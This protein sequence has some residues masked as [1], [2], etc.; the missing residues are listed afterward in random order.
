MLARLVMCIVS[1]VL[2]AMPAL[3]CSLSPGTL[4]QSNFE[5]VES[6]EAIV[7]AR[8]VEEESDGAFTDVAFTVERVLK[9]TPTDRVTRRDARLGDP[10]PSDPYELL[11][12]NPEAY[13]GPC[14][15]RTFKRG[16]RYVLM[17]RDDPAYGFIV[18]GNAFS[19][20]SEDD[21][22]PGSYWGRA[23]ETYLKIQ[24]NPDR[25]AQL[26]VMQELARSGLQPGA[27]R[28]D[29]QLGIDAL[30]HVLGIHPDK[31]TA[32]LLQRYDDPTAIRRA[33][34]NSTPLDLTDDMDELDLFVFAMV[35]DWPEVTPEP[36]HERDEILSALAQGNHP[37]AAPLLNAILQDPNARP[38]RLGS[39]LGYLI[40][41]GAFERF[42]QIYGERIL[43]LEAIG[44]RRE[45]EDFWRNV[46][47]AIGYG[48][49]LNV[50]D[51]FAVWWEQQR[52]SVCILRSAPWE[53]RSSIA[54]DSTLLDDARAHATQVLLHARDP[55]VIDWAASEI[56][57]LQSEQVEMY[58]HDWELP[59]KVLLAGFHPGDKTRI[60]EFA[61]GTWRQ[62]ET[63]ARLIGEVPTLHTEDLLR[64]M[65][66]IE[67]HEYVRNSLLDSAVRIA[68]H[69]MEASS[70]ANAEFVAA[71][72]RSDGPLPLDEGEEWMLP[73]AP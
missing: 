72:A 38:Q 35:G 45:V 39:A 29:R 56:D 54:F 18:A 14:I 15:R 12:A 69:D 46:Q 43:W 70:R 32:W 34:S 65:M 68:A 30:A 16:D 47:D 64:E 53:C 7:I 41:Q 61:C 17:L 21:F 9:G 25:M 66:A 27:S 2:A 71:Y 67:Q 52:T 10:V 44:D 50:N 31:P 48:D 4:L 51:E 40:R 36:E 42:K 59:I 1:G 49:D 57:R 8:A 5:M 24:Q 73:C 22:G 60:F 3:A 11:N 58:K 23:I 33:F 62:R 55:G 37:D 6:S 19:R 20:Q 63:F 13:T 26:D 28:F